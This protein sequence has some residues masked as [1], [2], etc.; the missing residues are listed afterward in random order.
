MTFKVVNI[1]KQSLE[2]WIWMQL[3]LAPEAKSIL[4]RL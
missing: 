1:F 2:F 3:S 4:Y